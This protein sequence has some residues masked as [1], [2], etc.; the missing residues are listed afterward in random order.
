MSF[1]NV[2]GQEEAIRILTSY[3]KGSRLPHALIF[4]GPEGVGKG[5]VARELAKALNC[6]KDAIDPCDECS[7]CRRI[8]RLNHPDVSWVEPVGSSIKIEQIR[9]LRSQISLMPYEARYKVYIINKAEAMTE[10]AQNAFLKTLE[11]PPPRSYLILISSKPQ[12][13]LPTI[14]SRCQLLRF[15]GLDSERIKD[16]LISRYDL[17]SARAHFL[18]YLSGGRLGEAIGRIRDDCLAKKNRVIDEALS[19]LSKAESIGW[20]NEPKEE[21]VNRLEILIDW[22]RDLLLLGEGAHDPLINVDR[23]EDLIGLKDRYLAEALITN[24]YELNRAKELILANVN[25]KIALDVMVHKIK[26]AK[27]VK[28]V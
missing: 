15:R 19:N 18:A 14:S 25:P 22:Y 17:D 7:T 9:L 13:L 21:I 4:S 24:I 3:I 1:K 16:A 27:S 5:L 12:S 10:E 8:D 2:I 23:R 28:R 11:E 26:K 6:E 20:Q